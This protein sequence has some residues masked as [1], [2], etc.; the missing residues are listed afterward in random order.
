MTRRALRRRAFLLTRLPDI[1]N[2]TGLRELWLCRNRLRELPEDFVALQG[3]ER[4]Y[5]HDNK[6]AAVAE[7][8]GR[9]QGLEQLTLSGNRIRAIPSSFKFM[10]KL[11]RLTVNGNDPA[12]KFSERG[13]VL[14]LLAND[15]NLTDLVMSPLPFDGIP[16]D[17]QKRLRAKL[18]KGLVVGG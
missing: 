1:G 9:L 10:T 18:G 12:L 2:L 3:L 7:D 11:W 6:L 5:L 17:L 8:F 13:A 14:E 4:C 16:R 15:G